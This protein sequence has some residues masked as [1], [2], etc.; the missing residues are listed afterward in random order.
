MLEYSKTSMDGYIHFDSG[1]KIQF[2]KL[3]VVKT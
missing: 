1:V 2:N 3:L